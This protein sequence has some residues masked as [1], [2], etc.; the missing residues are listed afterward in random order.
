MKRNKGINIAAGTIDFLFALGL[1][2]L[3]VLY[4]VQIN[5]LGESISSLQYISEKLFAYNDLEVLKYV[6]IGIIG[7][8]GLLSFIFGLST[9][10]KS[11]KETEGY[12]KSGGCLITFAVIETLFLA[13]LIAF[14][15]LTFS[16]PAVVIVSVLSLV[17]FLR[18]IGIIR[19]YCEKK[20][21]AQELPA[22]N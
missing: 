2:T 1:F 21:Y 22:A 19:F 5:L 18:Y 8:I 20:K 9:I 3:I 16:I 15:V 10:S 4:F 14:L 11:R 7:L 6:L 13:L 12:Y 17:V